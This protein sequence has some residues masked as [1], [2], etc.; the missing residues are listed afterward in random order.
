M[1]QEFLFGHAN[2]HDNR[3]HMVVAETTNKELHAV[4]GNDHSARFPKLV[5]EEMRDPERRFNIFHTHPS[6]VPLSTTDVNVLAYLGVQSISAQSVEKGTDKQFIAI[7][8]MPDDFF[9]LPEQQKE[10]RRVTLRLVVN[11]MGWVQR[12]AFWDYRKG[13]PEGVVLTPAERRPTEIAII[14]GTLIALHREGWIEY[15]SNFPHTRETDQYAER[16]QTVLREELE[17]GPEQAALLEATRPQRPAGDL[18]GAR[19]DPAVAEPGGRVGSLHRWT[20]ERPDAVRGREDAVGVRPGDRVLEGGVADAGW[21]IRQSGVG[22]ESNPP[23]ASEVEGAVHESSM[24]GLQ[25]AR[26][27]LNPDNSFDGKPHKGGPIKVRFT[28]EGI[29]TSRGNPDGVFIGMKL[30][31]SGL[32]TQGDLALEGNLSNS[33]PG[34]MRFLLAQYPHGTADGRA[35]PFYDPDMLAPKIRRALEGARRDGKKLNPT[36]A[37][38]VRAA[39][40]TEA[41]THVSVHS[42]GRVF[43]HRKVTD[44]KEAVKHAMLSEHVPSDELAA[45]PVVGPYLLKII[46]RQQAADPDTVEGGADVPSDERAKH[47]PKKAPPAPPGI[48]DGAP[49]EIEIRDQTPKDLSDGS[50]RYW[51]TPWLPWVRPQATYAKHPGVIRSIDQVFRART[52]G[53][54][55]F[56]S[57]FKTFKPIIDGYNDLSGKEPAGDR[58]LTGDRRVYTEMIFH[59]DEEMVWPDADK[60]TAEARRRGAKNPEKIGNLIVQHH[61]FLRDHVA[62][63]IV[64]H[65]RNMRGVFR[66]V[67]RESVGRI[68]KNVEPG[69]PRKGVEPMTPKRAQ[70]LL[71]GYVDVLRADAERR[72]KEA[73]EDA[74]ARSKDEPPIERE[75]HQRTDEDKETVKEAEKILRRVKRG[76]LLEDVQMIRQLPSELY[77]PDISTYREGYFP[78][79]RTGKYRVL[80]IRE[81]VGSDGKTQQT[82]EPMEVEMG[83]RGGF[84]STDS[85]TQAIARNEKRREAEQDYD[86][87]PGQ[88]VITSTALRFETA[89]RIQQDK[90]IR[91]TTPGKARQ[92]RDELTRIN[93]AGRRGGDVSKQIEDL[94][95]KVGEKDVKKLLRDAADDSNREIRSRIKAEGRRRSLAAQMSRTGKGGFSKDVMFSTEEHIR[96]VA[97][98]IVNDRVFFSAT[99]TMQ[100]FGTTF[101]EEQTDGESALTKSLR[102]YFRDNMAWRAAPTK[103]L[104]NQLERS[105]I[106]DNLNRAMRAT[107]LDRVIRQPV[108]VGGLFDMS[109]KAAIFYAV[110]VGAFVNAPLLATVG[111]LGALHG[112]MAG[113]GTAGAFGAVLGTMARERG[114]ISTGQSPSQ[115]LASQEAILISWLKLFAAPWQLRYFVMNWSQL[116]LFTVPNV[117]PAAFMR[118]M[119]KAALF[120]SKGWLAD[121]GVIADRDRKWRDATKESIEFYGIEEQGQA[122]QADALSFLTP[123]SQRVT[124]AFSAARLLGQFRERA[125]RTT[126]FIVSRE[127]AIRK[128]LPTLQKLNRLIRAAEKKGDEVQAD[129]LREMRWDPKKSA[130]AAALAVVNWTQFHY[131]SAHRSAMLRLRVPIAQTWFQ[132]ANYTAQALASFGRL[133]TEGKF[134]PGGGEVKTI[135]DKV[136]PTA[137]QQLLFLAVVG[138]AY[139]P[140]KLGIWLL[141]FIQDML[142]GEEDEPPPHIRMED[143]RLTAAMSEEWGLV[144]QALTDGIPAAMGVPVS[145]SVGMEHILPVPGGGLHPAE[146][147][148]FPDILFGPF[149]QTQYKVAEELGQEGINAESAAQVTGMLSP[150][151]GNAAS[152][153]PALLQKVRDGENTDYRSS[154]GDFLFEDPSLTDLGMQVLNLPSKDAVFRQDVRSQVYTLDQAQRKFRARVGRK[155]RTAAQKRDWAEVQKQALRFYRYGQGNALLAFGDPGSVVI[156]ELQNA[157]TPETDIG[158]LMKRLPKHEIGSRPYLRPGAKAKSWQFGDPEFKKPG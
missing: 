110:T 149:L 143:D 103:W 63:T 100:K 41:F 134:N 85:A 62:K 102:R 122:A 76:P 78:H 121:K 70:K 29:E 157:M 106:A 39:A 18:R 23:T 140:L 82:I 57:L 129:R 99:A 158:D 150:T 131:G 4:I 147:F 32:P 152:G 10:A 154:R 125:N 139:H 67:L 118:G 2:A 60:A 94:G 19:H 156:G 65:N 45:D 73:R 91:F 35:L 13:W 68:S 79:R 105:F 114:G 9:L 61:S 83:R 59:Y 14:E 11:A 117:G 132:F 113:A 53:E 126:T 141:Y 25:Q 124:G 3:E 80:R 34:V 27:F 1:I 43:G 151:W 56:A 5:L 92:L 142:W 112:L 30:G 90:T 133:A 69:K 6:A 119:K 145:G 144:N 20:G 116:L 97:N 81:A 38:A 24:E 26:R 66:K 44:P 40:P 93:A 146:M 77:V 104:D 123:T 17:L 138:A 111:G 12:N 7:A 84:D 28:A 58:E 46:A 36:L 33:L 15:G 108:K 50:M 52:E 72:A 107:H 135:R 21:T 153:V 96:S 101:T 136:L 64:D 89:M 8:R 98:W 75:K 148:R 48:F 95:I 31:A 42:D 71:A 16:F 74:M 87:N 128:G 130:D 54:A 120:R 22:K 137:L 55:A 115:N 37:D 109:I 88:Y 155:L 127:E 47:T 49:P 86:G 51:L